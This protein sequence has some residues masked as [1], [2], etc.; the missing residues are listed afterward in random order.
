MNDKNA[1][2][3]MV[4]RLRKYTEEVTP[5]EV[6]AATRWYAD[7]QGVALEM[8]HV[9]GV[10]LEQAASILSAYSPRV[11]WTRNV[12]LGIAHAHGD[13]LPCLG[14]SAK[15]AFRAQEEGFAALKGP[16]TNAFARAI[17]GDTDAVV[18]DVWICRAL[19]LDPNKLT[20]RQYKNA[21]AA[22]R[23]VAKRHGLTASTMQALIWIR[24]RGSAV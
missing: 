24:V 22:M 2:R 11:S 5:A 8:A 3:T 6:E 10:S 12:M 1:R 14:N 21:A 7:A 23:T 4:R 16:K 18:V 13:Y 15:A 20:P 17:A 9:Q 19:G